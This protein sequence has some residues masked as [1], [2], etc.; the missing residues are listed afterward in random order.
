VI[1]AKVFL[2]KTLASIIIYLNIYKTKKARMRSI[3]IG[4]KWLELECNPKNIWSISRL[5]KKPSEQKEHPTQKPLEMIER[6]V[7][8]SSPKKGFVLNPFA[9]AGI[10]S[11]SQK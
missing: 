7:K 5:H 4:N 2:Q 8:S 1:E 10:T 6:M 9:G 11:L 3:F